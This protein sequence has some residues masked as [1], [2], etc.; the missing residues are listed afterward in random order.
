MVGIS[1]YLN[2]EIGSQSLADE[3]AIIKRLRDGSSNIA[4]VKNYHNGMVGNDWNKFLKLGSVYGVDVPSMSL[5]ANAITDSRVHTPFASGKVTEI[6]ITYNIT[7]D[8]YESSKISTCTSSYIANMSFCL[9]KD[10]V[11]YKSKQVQLVQ[12]TRC[13]KHVATRD[14]TDVVTGSKTEPK[15]LCAAL[16]LSRNDMNNMTSET[17]SKLIEVCNTATTGFCNEPRMLKAMLYLLY[18]KTGN[19]IVYNPGG[20]A[21]RYLNALDISESVTSNTTYVYTKY[22]RHKEYNAFLKLI[23]S[24]YPAVAQ[25]DSMTNKIF[26]ASEW[27][28]PQDGAT[29]TLV[30]SESVEEPDNVYTFTESKFL[31][32]LMEY[33]VSV[34]SLGHYDYLWAK[35]CTFLSG[36]AV[37]QMCV[38]RRIGHLDIMLKCFSH[39]QCV[40]KHIRN[41][42]IRT[43]M[44]LSMRYTSQVIHMMCDIN[45]HL[46]NRL[47]HSNDLVALNVVLSGSRSDRDKVYKAYA[48]C[49]YG[50]SALVMLDTDPLLG[51]NVER[52]ASR[53]ALKDHWVVKL[54][55][56]SLDYGLIHRIV[57]GYYL[58]SSKVM[59]VSKNADCRV[60]G[61]FCMLGAFTTRTGVRTHDV[62]TALLPGDADVL[63][64]LRVSLC[65]GNINT[66][67]ISMHVHDDV[68]FGGS[69]DDS[70]A[71]DIILPN[72][73][74]SVED[75]PA[76][77]STNDILSDQR[78]P[79][80]DSGSVYGFDHSWYVNT[81]SDKEQWPSVRE[82][83]STEC[84]VVDPSGDNIISSDGEPNAVDV[85]KESASDDEFSEA[86]QMLNLVIVENAMYIRQVYDKCY[87]WIM[88]LQSHHSGLIQKSVDFVNYYD[89]DSPDFVGSCVGKS[90]IEDALR[91]DHHISVGVIRTV[92]EAI[93][94]H[95][96]DIEEGDFMQVLEWMWIRAENSIYQKNIK[97]ALD[98]FTVIKSQLKTNLIMFDGKA[99]GTPMLDYM[100]VWLKTIY[101]YY[102]KVR[103]EE[104]FK[105][106]INFTRTIT[107]RDM[108]YDLVKN[109]VRQDIYIKDVGLYINSSKRLV[110]M[111][112][113]LTRLYDKIENMMDDALSLFPSTGTFG[114]ADTSNV[115]LERAVDRLQL[116]INNLRQ[117]EGASIL[118]VK[119]RKSDNKKIKSMGLCELFFA[120]G[121]ELCSHELIHGRD[122][123]RMY[124]TLVATQNRMIR[125]RNKR[126]RDV[127]PHFTKEFTDHRSRFVDD[128]NG[129]I[130]I[131][132]IWES[133]GPTKRGSELNKLLHVLRGLLFPKGWVFSNYEIE[134]A[135]SETSTPA[136][137]EEVSYAIRILRS[138]GRK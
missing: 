9:F 32:Y 2:K 111:S 98:S 49:H 3:H 51:C 33:M 55:N 120:F 46:K 24:A 36:T 72:E 106:E 101:N 4:R 137:I 89:R 134:I 124:M 77:S 37:P 90:E 16:G 82:T 23:C 47:E 138:W 103:T 63:K 86:I 52:Y 56:N 21:S 109:K 80:I 108:F 1:D 39:P 85:E 88:E 8:I 99:N 40:S 79:K 10:V 102:N 30:S 41:I 91:R 59:D 122:A 115:V 58:D 26:K 100:N 7:S 34:K 65:E 121:S 12:S 29:V 70:C 11:D 92:F 54:F 112:E 129:Y 105:K 131:I 126:F 73:N 76:F 25:V 31:K 57:R 43:A 116:L 15:S 71:V 60:R 118:S 132:R 130:Y 64:S 95:G 81:A 96:Q 19:N 133:V 69:F 128:N 114:E 22:S 78:V 13:H 14:T 53:N 136:I 107:H 113:S 42:D 5:I 135:D 94:K 28:I 75:E 68:R 27:L 125:P 83:F 45:A 38:N 74:A 66:S 20:C 127:M 50:L 35:A 87:E 110:F 97:I 61:L 48:A 18:L 117:F 123:L 6:G 62:R 44:L 17:Q 93:S 84:D 119:V 67:F 104:F